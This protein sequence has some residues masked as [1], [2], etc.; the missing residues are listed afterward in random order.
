MT[1]DT[2]NTYTYDAENRITQVNG[3][4]ATYTYLGGLRVQR[5]FGGTT[6]YVYSGTVPIAEYNAGDPVNQPRREYIYSGAQRLATIDASTGT[7][8]Q[9]S[10]HLSTRVEADGSANVTRT[11]GHFPFGEIWYETGATSRWKFT[12][13]ERDSESGLDYAD[14]RFYS[15]RVGR[16][17]SADLLPGSPSD[18][19]SL[20][21]YAYVLG[22]VTDR[23]DPLGL[24]DCLILTP[25][26][27]SYVQH[28]CQ[29]TPDHPDTGPFD[30][31]TA[32]GADVCLG[33]P[34][35][36]GGDCLRPTP[37]PEMGC[38]YND[39]CHNNRQPKKSPTE[40]A[41]DPTK[42]PLCEEVFLD[43]FKDA[44][45][46]LV[47]GVD[48]VETLVQA[49]ALYYY[50]RALGYAIERGLTYPFKSSVFRGLLGT[51]QDLAASVPLLSLDGALLYA[52]IVEANAA[53]QG[54]CRQSAFSAGAT[55][56]VVP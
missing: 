5:Q 3:S 56:G 31:S 52:D 30:P 6:V 41:K 42:L 34:M 2:L 17:M 9:F 28:N 19:Q 39:G 40:D 18:P 37:N 38:K 47:P 12:T 27:R 1:N 55:Q 4:L 48:P 50:N 13:Y 14:F 32:M 45:A 33:G 11:F 51:S 44:M 16:F 26:G 24:R 7:T 20:D 49:G 15:S 23:L 53:R 46:P 10:D 25:D 36:A 43:A 54:Q 22:D 8:Y 35:N 21:R 29:A